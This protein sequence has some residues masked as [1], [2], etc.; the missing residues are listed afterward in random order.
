MVQS[1]GPV[2]ETYELCAKCTLDFR[3]TGVRADE[4]TVGERSAQSDVLR[5]FWS[6]ACLCMRVVF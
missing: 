6:V 3:I 5:S 1:A 4:N 2:G